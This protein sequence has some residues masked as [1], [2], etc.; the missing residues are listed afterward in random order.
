MPVF[1]KRRARK[2]RRE[3]LINTIIPEH[4]SKLKDLKFQF[5]RAHHNGEKQTH[6]KAE[7]SSL[8]TKKTSLQREREGKKKL[9]SYKGLWIIMAFYFSTA[10]L[11]AR[12]QE[13]NAI[14]T[15]RRKIISQLELYIQW[16][17][18]LSITPTVSKTLPPMPSFLRNHWRMCSPQKTIKYK[19]GRC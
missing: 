13:N 6:I 14:K 9:L 18:E 17:Y 4:F 16:N 8:E 19:R 5:R 10:M 3:D 1:C 12:K 15:W 2:N 11:E 7:F